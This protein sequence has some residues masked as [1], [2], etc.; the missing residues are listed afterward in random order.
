[1]IRVGFKVILEVSSTADSISNAKSQGAIARD[2]H[3]SV[4]VN[5]AVV[6]PRQISLGKN[7]HSAAVVLN[8]DPF[9]GVISAVGDLAIVGVK[10]VET[11]GNQAECSSVSRDRGVL[12]DLHLSAGKD[13]D[14]VQLILRNCRGFLFGDEIHRAP[15][16]DVLLRH[17]VE[18]RV[19]GERR[20]VDGDSAL[21]GLTGINVN[22][23]ANEAGARS[24]RSAVNEIQSFRK[25]SRRRERTGLGEFRIELRIIDRQG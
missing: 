21:A 16:A 17:D 12:R 18:I 24:V 15:D 11:A 5:V 4:T 9:E 1:L 10:G 23:L 20:Q 14:G 22:V 13:A 6:A 3:I 2:V 8:H 7:F 19:A 25:I